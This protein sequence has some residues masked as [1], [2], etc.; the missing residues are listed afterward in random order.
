MLYGSL[1]ILMGALMAI[2]A[3]ELPCQESGFCSIGLIG[4]PFVGDVAST[5]ERRESHYFLSHWDLRYTLL[6]LYAEGLERALASCNFRDEIILLSTTLS[7]L[8]NALQLYDMLFKL[9]FAHQILLTSDNEVR[10]TPLGDQTL[11]DL[12]R[13]SSGCLI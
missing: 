3:Q 4:P 5:G 11:V 6:S 13:S 2:S 7:V 8:D 1:A 12:I 10:T 9:G